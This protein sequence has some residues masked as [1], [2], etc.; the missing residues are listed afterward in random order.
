MVISFLP[1]QMGFLSIRLTRKGL[2]R[3]YVESCIFEIE[4]MYFEEI[5]GET[6]AKRRPRC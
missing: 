6:V 4:A 3:K 2:I 5:P 1:S